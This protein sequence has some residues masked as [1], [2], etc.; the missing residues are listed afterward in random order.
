MADH[1]TTR[2]TLHRLAIMDARVMATDPRIGRPIAATLAMVAMATDEDPT[3]AM[4]AIDR[5]PHTTSQEGA[6]EAMVAA[7]EATVVATAEDR[8]LV[9]MAAT[10]VMVA[11]EA[12]AVAVAMVATATEVAMAATAVATV[13]LVEATTAME[14]TVAIASATQLPALAA[15]LPSSTRATMVACSP[16]TLLPSTKASA[17]LPST[18]LR[19]RFLKCK[20]RSKSTQRRRPRQDERIK[21]IQPSSINYLC[22]SIHIKTFFSKDKFEAKVLY[23]VSQIV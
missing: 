14:G 10:V 21:K 19:R 20:S 18:R 17:V 16:T 2:A 9:A 4:A 7:T 13:A 5:D 3:M 15:S 6:M 11:T 23:L 22:F 8:P 12:T 1:A